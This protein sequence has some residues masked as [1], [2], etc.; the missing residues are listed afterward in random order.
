MKR[1]E[2]YLL[3]LAMVA[4]VSILGAAR[5]VGRDAKI[6]TAG[7]DRAVQIDRAAHV[8]PDYA[9]TMIPPNIA[10][11]T[12][13]IDEP[14]TA[15]CVRLKGQSGQSIQATSCN[16]GVVFPEKAWRE[17]LGKHRGKSLAFEIHV[18]DP[19]GQWRRFETVT[20][21]VAAED[22]DRYLAYRSIRPL[23]NWY[24]NVGIYQRDLSSYDRS[25]ILH[26]ESYGG[27]CVN[28]HTFLNKG[29]DKM[30]IGVRDNVYASA[31]LLIDNDTVTKIGTRFGYTSWHPSGKLAVYS[32]NKVRLFFHDT[33]PEV[34]DVV[35]LDSALSIYDVRTQT[36]K[37]DPNIAEKDRLETYP[38][39]SPDGKYLYFCSAPIL[40]EDRDTVPPKNFEKVRYDLRRVSYDI[41]TDTWGRPE[42]ILSAES[43]GQSVLLPRIS[44]DGR[45]L[46]CCLCD[47]GCFPVYRADSD[48]YCID[49]QEGQ[50]GG[51]YVS[52][53][54]TQANS[55]HSE[56]WHS[57]SSNG[58]WLVFSS[59]RDDDVFTRPWFCYIDSQG[60]A[61][62]PFVLPQKDP[63][64]YETH[65]KTFNTPE[66]ATEPVRISQRKLARA[67]R[68]SQQ[69][70]AKLPLT[71]A[72][73]KAG[74]S[75]TTYHGPE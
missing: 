75:P 37:S 43:V 55:D 29:T 65:L 14:G 9:G 4:A 35:D 70:E 26:G 62:K 45:F 48:L 16:G 5:I 20:V 63:A 61:H 59:K 6:D 34:R 71:G 11:L 74:P 24:E 8:Q 40:W 36:L 21:S 17:L 22:I 50:A 56:S 15:Y 69:V 25:A 57:F 27:G 3:I 28:C 32:I 7:L 39:W 52:R 51:Q 54:L 60:Q 41:A 44:P 10:P 13:T 30:F 12:F 73:P 2:R 33:E 72:T 1:K 18:K 23:Y 42:T 68:S 64:F 31:T 67:V 66:F 53:P 49:L 47:Y 46:V 19:Q 58:R 38:A